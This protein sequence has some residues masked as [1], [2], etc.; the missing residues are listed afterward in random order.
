MN[1]HEL[2]FWRDL[3]AALRGIRDEIKTVQQDRKA[4]NNTT[5]QSLPTESWPNSPLPLPIAIREHYEAKERQ[6]NSR[7]ERIKK[8]LEVA[9]VVSAVVI[10]GFTVSTFH[11]IRRQADDAT[12]QV[13]LMQKQLELTDRPWIEIVDIKP[14]D[15]LGGGSLLF[16]DPKQ[17][18][19]PPKEM[20]SLA[21]EVEYKNV[22]RSPAMQIQA[23][24]EVY[25]MRK[26]ET[27]IR[28]EAEG[29]RF[30]SIITQTNE[31]TDALFPDKSR[32]KD[33]LIPSLRTEISEDVVFNNSGRL[34]ISPYLIVCIDYRYGAS[35][36]PHQTG[37][38][39]E[40]RQGGRL[41]SEFFDIGKDRSAEEILLRKLVDLIN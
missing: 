38:V 2:R 21:F 12:T 4:N 35:S 22:G 10:A 18:P 41:R 1:N 39:Y 27:T 8:P 15:V 16:W 24:R 7:W 11:Q 19:Y 31:E 28:I 29:K 20:V 6:R 40:I 13:N 5:Q 25:L 33:Y 9:G 37:A 34:F 26:T 17:P 32:T 14:V 3:L 36:L 23:T 30:C